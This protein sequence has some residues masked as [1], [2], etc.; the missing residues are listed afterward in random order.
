LLE[1]TQGE[2]AHTAGKFVVQY[3]K[4]PRRLSMADEL[5]TTLWC[6]ARYTFTDG[7]Q[8]YCA[9][10]KHHTDPHIFAE[11]EPEI[12]VYLNKALG[13]IVGND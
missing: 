11:G 2:T 10:R 12:V 3:A 13:E 9:N 4:A 8:G 1:I 5:D 7:K 6:L